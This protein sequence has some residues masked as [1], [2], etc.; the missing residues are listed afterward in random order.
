M[1]LDHVGEGERAARLRR[2]LYRAVH[3]DRI[4]TRDLGGATSTRDFAGALMTR[5]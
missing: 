5:L 4:W 3:E 2:A 1:M